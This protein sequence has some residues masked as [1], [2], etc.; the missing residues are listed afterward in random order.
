MRS[1]SCGVRAAA[2]ALAALT[3]L[4]CGTLRQAQ[5]AVQGW[6]G[7]SEPPRAY[8]AGAARAKLYQEPDASSPVVG[9]LALHEGVLG[10]RV[11]GGFT[12]VRAEQSGRSGWVRSEQLIDTLPRARKP[13]PAAAPQKPASSEA[14]TPPAEA[15]PTETEAPP[16]EV[17][18]EPEVPGPEPERSVFDPY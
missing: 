12:Y 16:P 17:P 13:A 14:P 10:Y 8:Y 6:F 5:D 7:R 1:K 9:E 11:D 4:G 18:E 2:L 3:L 15:T